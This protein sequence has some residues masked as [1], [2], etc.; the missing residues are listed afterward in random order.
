MQGTLNLRAICKHL[1]NCLVDPYL[2]E[3]PKFHLA[4][5]GH[6]EITMALSGLCGLY[7]SSTSQLIAKSIRALHNIS[8]TLL[9]SS[10][11]KVSYEECLRSG[12]SDY[13]KLVETGEDVQILQS[14]FSQLPKLQKIYVGK[15]I[16]DEYHSK[17]GQGCPTWLCN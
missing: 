17:H 10:S 5:T 3:S 14:A 13:R 4:K 9:V 2:S 6:A 1:S 12:A 8:S 7:T 15:W 16:A 11:S